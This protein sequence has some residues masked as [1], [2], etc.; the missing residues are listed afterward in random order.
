[1]LNTSFLVDGLYLGVKFG[2]F[3]LTSIENLEFKTLNLGL[4]ANYQLVNPRSLAG[5]IKW[6]GVTV[7]SGFVYQSST[8]K[9]GM[10]LDDPDP[11]TGIS[12]GGYTASL[13]IKNPKAELGFEVSTFTIPLEVATS[14]RLLWILNL[15]VGAGVDLAF[16]SSELTLGASGD[17]GL[18]QTAGTDLGAINP[19]SLSVSGGGT[20]SPAFFHPK[21]TAGL[22]ISLGPVVIDVPFA[23]YFAEQGY[24]VGVTVGIIW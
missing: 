21:V 8:I 3:N 15:A 2:Y 11:V 13:A 6:R 10:T 14:V 4:V 24:S 19:G 17:I 12:A 23:Y 5:I 7:G 20:E 9:Y 16:G 18:E 1:M 22:G